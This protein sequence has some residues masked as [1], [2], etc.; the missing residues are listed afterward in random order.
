MTANLIKRLQ[1]RG[2]L[3]RQALD[4]R[5]VQM[6]PGVDV[7]QRDAYS[8]LS[9]TRRRIGGSVGSRPKLFGG[10]VDEYCTATGDD[11]PLIVR[12]C[13]R[14]LSRHGLHHQVNC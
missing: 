6:T 14:M 12:S 2:H 13:V 1:A 10:S 4:G 3:L 8:S 11:I 7:I 9:N 5:Q